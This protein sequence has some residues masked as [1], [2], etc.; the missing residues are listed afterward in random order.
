MRARPLGGQSL[1]CSNTSPPKG[2]ASRCAGCGGRSS[3]TSTRAHREVAAVTFVEECD[4]TERRP[5]SGSS[6]STLAAAAAVAAGVPGAERA[7]RGRRDRL[8]RALRPRRRRADRPGPRRP[9]R[10]RLR[11]GVARRARSGGR[12]AR[13]GRARRARSTPEEL[14]G[15]TFTVTS[16]GKLGGL[17]V[18][19]LVNHP[20]V[21]ILGI[22]RIDDRPVVRDG[23]RSSSA[24]SATSRPLRPP[25]DRRRTRR[26]VH[27]LGDPQARAP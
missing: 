16:A 26:R 3:S 9:G 5:A 20:E 6:R 22:H 18:T 4:F 10:P 13:R 17:L 23:E 1:C 8:P 19:P 25:R 7:A 11:H 12:A 15:G 21:A 24:G 2:A 14:R 27:A